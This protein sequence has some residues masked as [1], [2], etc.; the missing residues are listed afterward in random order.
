MSEV[1]AESKKMIPRVL[2]E[3]REARMKLT[4]A[5]GELD[6]PVEGGELLRLLSDARALIERT[7]GA[8]GG[9]DLVPQIGVAA[10]SDSEGTEY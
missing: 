9:S 5:I 4:H 1:Y 3:L 2:M 10:C 6:L 7:S 8:V